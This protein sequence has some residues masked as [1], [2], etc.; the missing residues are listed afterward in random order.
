M[1][2]KKEDKSVVVETVEDK[3]SGPVEI[4]GA[5]TNQTPNYDIPNGMDIQVYIAQELEKAKKEIEDKQKK[6][7]MNKIAIGL[8][9]LKKEAKEGAIK[10]DKVTQKELM[11]DDGMTPQR[12]DTKFYVD[13]AFMGGSIRTEVNSDEY[14]LLVPTQKYFCK[15]YLG[16]VTEF[17]KSS[18]QPIFFEYESL[19]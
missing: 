5:E 12:Y 14:A 13:F 10:K 8:S 17:G 6:A 18:I 15:G 3:A 19:S 1:A 16:E 9:V 2:Q 4:Q 11:H 7:D